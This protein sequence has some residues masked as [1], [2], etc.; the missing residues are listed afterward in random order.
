MADADMKTIKDLDAVD[1]SQHPL[2][3]N[4]LFVVVVNEDS[5]DRTKKISFPDLSSSISSSPW[6]E[7]TGTLTTGSTTITLSDA[8]ITTD[9]TID[10]YTSVF[11]INPVGIAVATGY[12]TITFEAQDADIGVKVRVT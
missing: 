5:H 12:V 8:S 1:I 6:V 7:V 9:S 3:S 11:G 2:D 10:V 4:T